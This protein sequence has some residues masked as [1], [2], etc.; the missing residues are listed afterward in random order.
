MGK[1][2]IAFA[3]DRDVAV[4]ALD[5][6]LKYPARPLALLVS[7]NERSTHADQLIELCSFL[8]SKHVLRGSAFRNPEGMAFL[9]ELNLDYIVALHF[10]YLVPEAILSI[11]RRGWLNLH[12][13]YLPYNRGWH[14]PSWS[15]LEETDM[16][17]TLHFM[18]RGIDT[19]DIVHQKRLD[20]SPADTAHSLYGR[21]KQLELEVFKEAWPWI[22][23]GDY[24][25]LP[26]DPAGGTTHKRQD[27]FSAEVQKLDLD[28]LLTT[29]QL[30]NKLRGLST[31]HVEE[32]AYYEE[33]G[34]RFRVQV[35]IREDTSADEC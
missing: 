15:I 22:L 24:K 27:L 30:L 6:V 17:A 1:P 9:R 33:S 34:R 35:V 14:T 32:A 23:S 31:N 19:G 28:R 5:Y 18:D 2:R 16:G 21:V 7:G 20:V 25:R 29:R 12:P 13:A 4:W 10:P 26:Q 3:G 8:E 11:P